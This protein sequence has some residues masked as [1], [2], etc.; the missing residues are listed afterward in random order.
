MSCSVSLRSS[1]SEPRGPI[2]PSPTGQLS[3]LATGKL[4]CMRSMLR[5][6]HHAQK[7]CNDMSEPTSGDGKTSFVRHAIA[8]YSQSACSS[9]S[10]PDREAT[11][12]RSGAALASTGR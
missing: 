3:T 9:L 10:A 12:A 4:T 1:S 2:S 11:D 6:Q 7:P 5:G 8:P